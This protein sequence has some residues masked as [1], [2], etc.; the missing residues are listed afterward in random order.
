MHMSITGKTVWPIGC[1]ATC[2]TPA[3]P[4]FPEAVQESDTQPGRDWVFVEPW[5]VDPSTWCPDVLPSR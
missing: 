3:D 4:E 1:R 2:H 5:R